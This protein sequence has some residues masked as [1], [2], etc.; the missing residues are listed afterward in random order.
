MNPLTLA[1][2]ALSLSDYDV[3]LEFGDVRSVYVS[4]KDHN[5]FKL[6]VIRNSTHDKAKQ[7]ILRVA[8]ISDDTSFLIGTNLDT[9]EVWIIPRED[10][11]GMSTIRLGKR[12]ESYR[13]R[14]CLEHNLTTPV[15][16]D[17]EALKSD[18]KDAIRSVKE[19]LNES[20]RVS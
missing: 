4:K 9:N 17:D 2:C 16:V 10:I 11:D 7:R 18:V 19:S 12:W 3:S 8:D 14:V 5:D 20:S 13:V 6:C 1:I 15:E